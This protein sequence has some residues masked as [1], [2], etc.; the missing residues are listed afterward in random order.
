MASTNRLSSWTALLAVGGLVLCGAAPAFAQLAPGDAAIRQM[1]IEE[2][3]AAYPGNCPCP[4]NT[5]RNG[6]RC[7]GNS[8]WSKPG[9]RS[10]LCYPDDIRQP[11]LDDYKLRKGLR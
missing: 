7:G 5:M 8:A 3:I 11:I 1:M 4:F 9:G 10:P 6:R 2:S